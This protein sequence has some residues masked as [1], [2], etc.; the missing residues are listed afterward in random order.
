MFALR[1]N[2]SRLSIRAVVAF[3]LCVFYLASLRPIFFS[4]FLHLEK[5]IYILVL[6]VIF[7]YIN[8]SNTSSLRSYLFSISTIFLSI[9]LFLFKDD[10]PVW[11]AFYFPILLLLIIMD[12]KVMVRSAL[13]FKKLMCYLLII[14]IAIHLLIL[15]GVEIPHVNLVPS[16][17]GAFGITYNFYFF[18]GYSVDN[19]I[20]NY[21][22]SS[23]FDEPGLLG[24][25]CA[26]FLFSNNWDLRKGSSKIFL[27]AGILS[28]SMAFFILCLFGYIIVNRRSFSKIF[29]ILLCLC[30]LVFI[31]FIYIDPESILYRYTIQRIFSG[32]LNNRNV[33]DFV[34]MWE[35]YIS[36]INAYTFMIGA[37]TSS[38]YANTGSFSILLF[39]HDYGFF[40]MGLVYGITFLSFMRFSRVNNIIIPFFIM[41]IISSY[42]R[43]DFF[44]PIYFVYI[45]LMQHNAF[46]RYRLMNLSNRHLDK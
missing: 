22:F 10:K 38:L 45:I 27:L 8:R 43:P 41:F 29:I 15:S 34:I 44:K 5:I 24:T 11:L 46:G 40:T 7:F 31:L 2:Y 12:R 25:L 26:F 42:Q 35:H 16:H 36:N 33:G 37:K 30:S 20:I 6:V 13:M 17:K 28:L 1:G 4:N 39:I 21:R 14:G 32:K 3:C 23:V 19:G 9:L 18:S